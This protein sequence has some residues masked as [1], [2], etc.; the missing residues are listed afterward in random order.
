[1][2][3]LPHDYKGGDRF[4]CARLSEARVCTARKWF[5]MFCNIL[6]RRVEAKLDDEPKM[7]SMPHDYKGG[8]RFKCARLSEARVCTKRMWFKMF[9]NILEH[10]GKAKLDDEPKMPN[11]PHH[12]KC[13]PRHGNARRGEPRVCTSEKRSFCRGFLSPAKVRFAFTSKYLAGTF[14]PQNLPFPYVAVRRDRHGGRA[15]VLWART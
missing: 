4:K 13:G 2:P 14:R 15:H 3:S 6:E 12:H 7:P 9:C 8:D 5:K 11:T 1:M 10:R